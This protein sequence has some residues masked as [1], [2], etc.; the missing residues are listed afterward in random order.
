MEYFKDLEFDLPSALLAQLVDL[1]ERMTPGPLNEE[2]VLEVPEEQGVY[3]L[4]FNGELVYVGKTDADAG[5]RQRLLRHAKKIRSRR[6]L[7]QSQVTFKA[8]RVYVFTAMDLED[9]LI[10]HYRGSGISL[11]WNLSGFGSNDPGRKRDKSH[12]KQGHFDRL[13]PIDLNFEVRV[14]QPM[15][16]HSVAEVLRQLKAQLA[17]TVRFQNKGA[18]SKKPHSDLEGTMV[19]LRSEKDSVLN[20]LRQVKAALGGAWQITALPGYVIIYR[21]RERYPQGEVIQAG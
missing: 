19:R 10:K 12:I 20:A 6:N 15:D 9:L 13:F 1:F 3:Q 7:H 21:E 8:V 2:T 16:D 17:Y 4:F 14:V 5:L 18:N 11:A